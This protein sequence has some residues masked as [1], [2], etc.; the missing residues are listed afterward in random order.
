MANEQNLNPIRSK[1]KARELGAKGGVASGKA[2][3]EK[4]T[5]RQILDMIGEETIRT[6]DGKTI[7]KD[8]AMCIKQFNNAINGDLNAFMAICKLRGELTDKT[9]ITTNGKDIVAEPIVVEVIDKR[10]QVK[11]EE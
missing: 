3:R 7:T 10:E 4:K 5:L 11:T 1:K 6:T 2:K 9:D 8:A